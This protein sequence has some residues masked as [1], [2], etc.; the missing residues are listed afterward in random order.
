MKTGL[1][2][3]S[4]AWHHYVATY[5]GSVVKLFVDGNMVYSGSQTG[6]LDS[7]A[8]NP[9]IGWGSTFSSHYHLNG[10]IDEIHIYNRAL[11]EAEIR[12]IY[13]YYM[14]KRTIER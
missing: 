1:P 3:L 8:V 14:K 7:G 11:S 12:A 6:N 4:N 2:S 5:D 10:L 13:N 9:T